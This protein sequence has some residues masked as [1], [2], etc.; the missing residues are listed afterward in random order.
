MADTAADSWDEEYDVVVAGA[1]LAGTSCAV[2][3]ATEGNGE[4]I[5]LIDKGEDGPQG[6]SALSLGVA[7]R[8]EDPDTFATYV[9]ALLGEHTTTPEAVIKA[10]AQGCA[11]HVS[12]V[13]SLGADMSTAYLPDPTER[14]AEGYGGEYPELPG[15][16]AATWFGLGVADELGR[17]EDL[18]TEPDDGGAP[19]LGQFMLAKC[20]ELSDSI[21]YRTATALTALV[22]DPETKEILGAVTSD[23]KRI[24]AKK[25]VL[26]AV[27]GFVDNP[28]LMEDYLNAGAVMPAAKC[29]DEGDGIGIC[30]KV[31]VDFWHMSSCG[32]WMAPCILD[33]S[34]YTG[35]PHNVFSPK[36]YGITVGSNGRRFYMDWDG[37]RCG[38]VVSQAGGELDLVSAY[39]H[40]RTSFGGEF[41][42]LSFPS[43]AWFVFDQAGLDAG[44]LANYTADEIEPEGVGYR[45]DT[46]E[47]LAEKMGVPADELAET[48]ETWNQFCDE[49]RD[50]AFFRPVDSLHKIEQAPYFAQLCI[51]CTTNTFGGPR[52]DEAGRILNFEGEPIPGLYGAGEFGSIFDGLYNGGGNISECMVFGRNSA[53]DM[54]ANR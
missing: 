20:Q 49:G 22:Q 50:R 9:A 1:G 14:N 33:K 39:R 48:V 27:G 46:L 12:W 4:K 47:E 17:G 44:A 15:W 11:E 21:T 38:D 35:N 24:R 31:G 45:A 37:Y 51:P 30:Q 18:H 19:H 36:Q 10:Y 2:T 5:L 41:K 25:G 52:H 42:R 28:K 34:V 13:E 3:V 32:M 54:I 16:E 6:H 7:H 40:G 43:Q 29:L 8:T 26:V 53:R 23:G